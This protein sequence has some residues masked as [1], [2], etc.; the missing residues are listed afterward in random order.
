MNSPV[1]SLDIRKIVTDSD[2]DGIVTA[3]ILKRHWRDAEIIFAH[4]G[5]LRSGIL[6]GL[7]DNFTAICDLPMTF[8]DVG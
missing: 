7:I 1:L 3:A 5:E 8:P 6:D 2:L 4:P